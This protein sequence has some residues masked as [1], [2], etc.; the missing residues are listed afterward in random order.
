MPVPCFVVACLRTT[1]LNCVMKPMKNGGMPFTITVELDVYFTTRLFPRANPS[2]ANS[3]QWCT[4]YDI[5]SLL[6][7]STKPWL[8]DPGFATCRLYALFFG[9]RLIH[10][11]SH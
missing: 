10:V 1:A 3:R 6:L 7:C 5:H 2:A 4:S 8:R 11:R 9:Y